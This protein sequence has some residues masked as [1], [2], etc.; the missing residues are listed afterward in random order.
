MKTQ[1]LGLEKIN[2]PLVYLKT[3]DLISYNEQIELILKNGE[4]RIGNVVATN[5]D[6]TIIQVYEGTT[7]IDVDSVRTELNGKPLEV[8]LSKDMLGRVFNGIGKP[9]DG[10]GEIKED[11]SRDI[12]GIPMN[13]ISRKYPRNYIE[14]GISVI[15]G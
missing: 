12:N 8:K 11:I 5:E 7:G 6:V 13:P 3:P 14:T 15:D 2:G 9:I 10:L 4:R 1:Y